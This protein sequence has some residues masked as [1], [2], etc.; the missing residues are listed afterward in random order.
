M[1]QEE[2]PFGSEKDC[3]GTGNF[4]KSFF[5]GLQNSYEEPSDE[6][7]YQIS[8]GEWKKRVKATTYERL[9]AIHEE[10]EEWLDLVLD[11]FNR[12]K[13]NKIQSQLMI[14]IFTRQK[15]YVEYVLRQQEARAVAELTARF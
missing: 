7:Y 10:L 5:S 8:W 4:I 12:G 6:S 1:K 11:D 9:Q 13:R 3:G 2:H 15:E 14:C